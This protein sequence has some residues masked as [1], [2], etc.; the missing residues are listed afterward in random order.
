MSG[1]PQSNR[2][3]PKTRVASLLALLLVATGWKFRPPGFDPRR[4]LTDK[5]YIERQL[6][7]RYVNLDWAAE[8]GSPDPRKLDRDVTVA[9]RNARSD[10]EARTILR[11]FVRSFGDGHMG[12]RRAN[13]PSL[14]PEADPDVLLSRFTPAKTACRALKFDRSAEETLSFRFEGNPGFR[15]R[16]GDSS[17]ASAVLDFEGRRFGFVRIGSFSE[18]HYAGACLREWPFFR[19][20]LRGT[21]EADCRFKFDLRVTDRLLREIAARIRELERAGT[22]ILVIDVTG[23]PG[24]HGWY[25]LAAQLFSARRLPPLRAAYVKNP[26]T[27]DSLAEDRRQVAHYLRRNLAPALRSTL[28]QAVCRLDDLIAEA[29]I[30]CDSTY[31]WAGRP[32][33]AGCSRL[34]TRPLYDAGVLDSYDGPGLPFEVQSGIFFDAVYRP[35]QPVWHGPVAVLIDEDTA[36]AAELFAGI[37]KHVGGVTLVGRHSASTGSGWSLGR[38]PWILPESKMQLYIPDTVAYWP[39]GANAREGLEPDIP[40]RWRPGEDPTLMGKQLLK[41]LR[42]LDFTPKPQPSVVR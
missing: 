41:A 21:C 36:S 4:W 9:L 8:R 33:Q 11:G 5:A 7:E 32:R 42:S 17:F 15:P 20:T 6:R 35:P 13:A 16:E 10:G 22:Q 38:R 1:I 29:K 3:W 18:R 28:E 37:L 26:D 23:N 2:L 31:I 12:L 19:E 25:R 40:T 24:G 39:D 30:P 27:V 14:T 34:T